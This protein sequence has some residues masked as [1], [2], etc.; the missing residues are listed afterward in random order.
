MLLDYIAQIHEIH[1]YKQTIARALAFEGY[2]RYLAK[3]K[4]HLT[5]VYRERRLA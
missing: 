1:L 2:N 4:I 3:R 5:E